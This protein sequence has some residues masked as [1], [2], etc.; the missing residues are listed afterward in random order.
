MY[1]SHMHA[2]GGYHPEHHGRWLETLDTVTHVVV[3]DMNPV[4]TRGEA[5]EQWE[6]A[7]PLLARASRQA[8]EPS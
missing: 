8:R 1:L 4:T 5:E 6:M 7:R 2:L 3:F